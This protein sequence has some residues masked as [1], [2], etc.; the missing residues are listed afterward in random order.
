MKHIRTHL[1]H[2]PCGDLLLGSFDGK[3][4]LCDWTAEKHREL[5][6]RRLRHILRA[7]Y[8][9]ETSPVIREAARQLDEYFSRKRTAFDIPIIFAG[10]QFQE[11][12]WRA[13][14]K[15]PYGATISYAALAG[16]IG[17]PKSVR[18]VAN[19]NGANAISIFIP[20]HRVIGSDGSLTGYGGGLRAKEFLLELEANAFV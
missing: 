4:C 6:N 11:S 10:T 18:A 12:V 16:Q 7:D 2:S 15:I 14:P 20:C 1:Y 5:V 19:A 8:L 13:L 17:R 3:L 9:E